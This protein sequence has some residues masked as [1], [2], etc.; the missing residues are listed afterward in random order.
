MGNGTVFSFYVDIGFYL[1][2]KN[3]QVMYGRCSNIKSFVLM[4]KMGG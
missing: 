3:I 4:M 2:S 1:S